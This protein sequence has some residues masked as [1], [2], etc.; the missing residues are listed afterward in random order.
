MTRADVVIRPEQRGDHAEIAALL[1]AAFDGPAEA[2]LV[3]RL[4]DDNDIALA[5]LAVANGGEIVG[6]IACPRLQLV[7]A[8]RRIP[9]VGVAPLA[10]APARQR[11]GIGGALM[12]ASLER[13]R[14]QGEA[15]VFVLG[16]PAYYTR[17]GLSLAVAEPF[18]S[19]YAGPHFMALALRPD[20][21]ASGRLVYPR[22]F[23]DLG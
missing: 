8:E 6:H 15:L 20:A 5:L 21:P 16:D 13:L 12:A 22:A 10:V 1:T 3:M 14:Q 18:A 4:R 17:F 9:V 11:S 2:D 19:D 23:S 7:Q